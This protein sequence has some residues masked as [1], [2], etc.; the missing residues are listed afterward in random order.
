[1]SWNPR[2]ARYTLLLFLLLFAAGQVKAYLNRPIYPDFDNIHETW[3]PG[4]HLVDATDLE[5][6]ALEVFPSGTVVEAAVRKMGL[7][8]DPLGSGHCLPRAGVLGEGKDGWSVRPMT[9]RERWVWRIPMDIYRC[10][11]E[12]LER[13]K[14][15]GPSIAGRIYRFVQG[16]GALKSLSEL[17]KVHG[18][19]PGKLK[20]LVKELELP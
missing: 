3:P 4:G 2:Q 8:V 6:R 15:I 14:G 18:V 1:M 10:E 13:I 16:R 7:E 17:D 9:Q 12:D 11:P 5:N 19:G 20:M